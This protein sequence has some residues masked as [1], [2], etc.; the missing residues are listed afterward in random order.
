MLASKTDQIPSI[1]PKTRLGAKRSPKA[2]QTPKMTL[3]TAILA[4][5]GLRFGPPRG[6]D[7]GAHFGPLGIGPISTL[8]FFGPPAHK[9]LLH[10][11]IPK[12]LYHEN[13][14]PRG[15]AI[16]RPKGPPS[17]LRFR[18]RFGVRIGSPIGLRSG[19][20]GR[21]FR[22]PERW[23]L[24]RAQNASQTLHIQCFRRFSEPRRRP[25]IGPPGE[26]RFGPEGKPENL[27]KGGPEFLKTL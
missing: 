24:F 5:F 18:A 12:F 10:N 13:G 8:A 19:P 22:A 9:D 21:P 6:L 27:R 20:L 11:E 25:Q 23:S 1:L 4:R 16:R 3:Q 2:V 7:S 15:G 14:G 26:A 17:G